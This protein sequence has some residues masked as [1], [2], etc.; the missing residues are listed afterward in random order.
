M[1]KYYDVAFT[2]TEVSFDLEFDNKL[3]D[4]ELGYGYGESEIYKIIRWFCLDCGYQM[5]TKEEVR[6]AIKR[7][8]I[9]LEHV[10]T[11]DT[12]WSDEWS[13]IYITEKTDWDDDLEG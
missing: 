4:Y 7:G 12:Y 3:V 10:K 13:E 9:C 11:S 5:V 2:I 8:S 1:K 6:Q